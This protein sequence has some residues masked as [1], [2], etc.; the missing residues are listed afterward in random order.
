MTISNDKRI[1]VR[2]N[3]KVTESARFECDLH[4]VSQ[5]DVRR[6]RASSEHSLMDDKNCSNPQICQVVDDNHL[7]NCL[8]TEI[9]SLYSP[10][11]IIFQQP[12]DFSPSKTIHTIPNDTSQ[13]IPEYQLSKSFIEED[14]NFVTEI[15]LISL[16]GQRESIPHY[17][18]RV[19]P[20]T[21][22]IG[23]KNRDFRSAKR[24]TRHYANKYPLPKS[25][26][27]LTTIEDIRSESTE[28]FNKTIE[29]HSEED[30]SEGV[31]DED[32]D[33]LSL[34]SEQIE[35]T[36]DYF[37]LC[38]L[39]VSQ[40]TKTYEDL[41]AITQLLEEKQTDLELAAKIGKNLL[42]RNRDLQSR[43]VETEKNLCARDE[44]I[45]QLNHNLTVK[46]N[47]LRIFLRDSD[48]LADTNDDQTSIS[49]SGR[50]SPV[51]SQCLS[52]IGG[53]G[54]DGISLSSINFSQLNR[55]L[56]DLEEENNAL[57]Q[58]RNRMSATADA[59][60]EH[61]TALV[62]DCA[63][64]LVAANMHIR[65]LSD[66][67]AK[68]S[69]AFINQQSEV[70]R[71]LTRGLDL[72]SRVKQLTAENEMLINRLKEAQITQSFLT[73]ELK[74]S[75][76]KY[77]ECL[78]LYNEARSEIR[79]LR[80]RS[81]RSYYRPSS[82][83]SGHSV[84]N[85][86]ICHSTSTTYLNGVTVMTSTQSD[87]DPTSYYYNHSSPQHEASD[88]SSSSLDILSTQN[89]GSDNLET[90]L[91]AD[92][93]HTKLREYSADN[94][95]HL[96]RAME[97]VRSTRTST[98]PTTSTA[99]NDNDHHNNSNIPPESG[100]ED[101]VS[102]SGFVS[103]S[104]PSDNLRKHRSGGS[105]Q[106]SYSSSP[107]AIRPSIPN[108]SPIR[109]QDTEQRFSPMNYHHDY[110]YY[111]NQIQSGNHLLES[112]KRHS[113]L[114]ISSNSSEKGYLHH[115]L[116]HNTG[117]NFKNSFDDSLLSCDPNVVGSNPLYYKLPQRL[118]L[119]K[120]LD[121]SNV[122]QHWQHLA[123]PSFT[124]ALFDAP[125]PGVQ[126]RTGVS[127]ITNPNSPKTTDDHQRSL[128]P[129]SS[130]VSSSSQMIPLRCKGLSTYSPFD[131]SHIRPDA[132]CKRKSSEGYISMSQFGSSSS[133]YLLNNR[134]RA[135]SL[136]HLLLGSPPSS[137]SLSQYCKKDKTD[138]SLQFYQAFD[139]LRLNDSTASP[140]S[141]LPTFSLTSL[142]SAILPFSVLPSSSTHND[143]KRN[144]GDKTSVVTTTNTTTTATV[145][146]SS[147][148]LNVMGESVRLRPKCSPTTGLQGLLDMH[149]EDSNS[150][151]SLFHRTST[152]KS[153]TSTTQASLSSSSS[154]TLSPC[155]SSPNLVSLPNPQPPTLVCPTVNR[156]TSYSRPSRATNLT[157]ITE[158]AG[159]PPNSEQAQNSSSSS[160]QVQETSL[161]SN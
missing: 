159:S 108:I 151:K 92:L 51:R 9:T 99:N 122:L 6:N 128:P 129:R 93:A 65:T 105:E 121:G 70:T 95:R 143:D 48:Q 62:R 113:W 3:W 146:S 147:S 161:Q 117:I 78:T 10:S 157:E 136:D 97:Q 90:S 27:E 131:L 46:D 140:S 40:M 107:Y 34:T 139:H 43:L 66:E 81:R 75:R 7:D 11:N 100:L 41:D 88:G 23:Y 71:L 141:F 59:L 101:T 44:V 133:P 103:G 87:P 134:I 35:N 137:S 109:L 104:E 79:A 153:I 67:L 85:N 13:I 38:G 123:T 127:D 124:R 69:D 64:Q 138:E 32:D 17:R 56:Q 58:E 8:T 154:T 1:P 18:L 50:V 160:Q 25:I 119:I 28:T 60:D 31:E 42:E 142:V 39:R 102:S 106:V 4:L 16:T 150:S 14:N 86:P 52:S 45:S 72:E 22:F 24:I 155:R 118:K 112:E 5:G 21:A 33:T 77:D 73:S 96:F 89:P 74:T 36:L 156:P 12:L 68:K 115:H 83:I 144:I 55:K 84:V 132:K 19:D 91:A 61:E 125:L 54:G 76:D 63:R 126:S 111:I 114:G 158:E 29:Y 116:H 49:S 94:V 30:H 37:I 148:S 149:K 53:G 110:P 57:R 82:L 80:K 47:L 152:T 26:T 130:L 20:C 145:K 120:P 2:R 15:E 135:R 98:Y